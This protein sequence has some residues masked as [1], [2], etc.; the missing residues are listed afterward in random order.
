MPASHRLA[1]R[2]HTLRLA[3]LVG[4]SPTAHFF[5]GSVPDLGLAFRPGVGLDALAEL[6]PLPRCQ[7]QV[8]D[9]QL[10]TNSA[11]PSYFAIKQP[12]VIVSISVNFHSQVFSLAFAVG[13]NFNFFRVL[14]GLLNFVFHGLLQMLFFGGELP[15]GRRV[16]AALIVG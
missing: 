5:T 16:K 14:E 10:F 9:V 8:V 3:R 11:T 13:L 6:I 4:Q 2:S 1:Q 15:Y 12:V 7:V